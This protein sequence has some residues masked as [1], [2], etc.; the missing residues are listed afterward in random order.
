MGVSEMQLEL[1]SPGRYRTDGGDGSEGVITVL[2]SDAQQQLIHCQ[3][4]FQSPIL[5]RTIQASALFWLR[6]EYQQD[7]EGRQFARCTADVFVAFP[8]NAVETAARVASPVTN[9]IADRNFEEVAMFVRMMHLAMTRQPGWVEQ[10]AGELRGVQPERSRALVDTA[11]QV[12][13]EG[14]RQLAAGQEQSLT[15]EGLRLSIRRQP[16]AGTGESSAGTAVPRTALSPDASA[17]Q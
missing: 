10:T 13:V 1:L 5:T 2:Q 16:E 9:K 11:A 15:P 17:S 14:Q 12:F 7:A 4:A 6:T 3:G 8:S